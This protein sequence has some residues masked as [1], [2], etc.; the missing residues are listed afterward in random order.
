MAATVVIAL[1]AMWIVGAAAEGHE[2]PRTQ[3]ER[4][5]R[6]GGSCSTNDARA[7]AEANGGGSERFGRGSTELS[8]DMARSLRR[9]CA[10]WSGE[11]A[12]ERA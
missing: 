6:A 1:L 10:P 8:K 11:S 2:T 4:A 9:M 5:G 7:H 12:R 3:A